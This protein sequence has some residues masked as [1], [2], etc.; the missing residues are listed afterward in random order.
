MMRVEC[1]GG[2]EREKGSD[3]GA[4]WRRSQRSSICGMRGSWRG[5]NCE[6]V[7]WMGDESIGGLKMGAGWMGVRS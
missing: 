5:A 1:W 4:G 2:A 3:R 6:G 7:D